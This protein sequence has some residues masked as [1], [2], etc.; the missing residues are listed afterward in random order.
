MFLFWVYLPF[1]NSLNQNS[2]LRYVLRI[3]GNITVYLPLNAILFYYIYK[4]Y[5][6]PTIQFGFTRENLKK[7]IVV[8]IL[9]WF[10]LECSMFIA[11]FIIAS[12]TFFNPSLN[13]S[14]YYLMWFILLAGEFF[15]NSLY[16]ET[17]YRGLWMD[18]LYKSVEGRSSEKSKI[19]TVKVY[20][21][22]ATLFA[23]LHIPNR[24]YYGFTTSDMLWN[25]LYLFGFGI[26]LGFCYQKTKSLYFIIVLH[27]LS[28][29]G[30]LFTNNLFGTAFVLV[31]CSFLF[32]IMLNRKKGTTNELTLANAT[33][34]LN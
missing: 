9:L 7:A 14:T 33:I 13:Y 2:V 28:N 34:P 8:F 29:I 27:T 32:I 12:N 6:N 4:T 17:F 24:I 11:A 22:Q 16:E 15:G 10:I 30:V 23:L 20:C 5:K 1:V 31:P 3:L 26:W 21:I 19:T 18:T 25:L